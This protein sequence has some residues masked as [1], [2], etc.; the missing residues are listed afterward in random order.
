MTITIDF[1][2]D[3]A[4]QLAK[5]AESRG[6]P[7]AGLVRRWVRERLV[8]EHERSL[9]GGKDLSPRSKRGAGSMEVQDSAKRED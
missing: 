2:G 9:G 4:G 7:P 5:V 1:T 8:H 6:M 3:E